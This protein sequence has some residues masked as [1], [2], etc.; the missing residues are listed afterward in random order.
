[1]GEFSGR[2]A[3]RGSGKAG[4]DGAVSW[5]A[6]PAALPTLRVTA[7]RRRHD[8]LPLSPSAADPVEHAAQ[9]VS[10][11]KTTSSAFVGDFGKTLRFARTLVDNL[12][13]TLE[14]VVARCAAVH[15]VTVRLLHRDSAPTACTDAQPSPAAYL[16]TFVCSL[17]VLQGMAADEE[18]RL[19]RCDRLTA[20]N[21]LLIYLRELIVVLR[22][23]PPGTDAFVLYVGIIYGLLQ[24][25]LGRMKKHRKAQGGALLLDAFKECYVRVCT[26]LGVKVRF[27]E[28]PLAL[29][30][31][32]LAA[33]GS[34]GRLPRRAGGRL[35]REAAR[36]ALQVAAGPRSGR[37]PQPR[38]HHRRALLA[39]GGARGSPRA[40]PR[41]PRPRRAAPQRRLSP[42]HN[43]AAAGRCR[44]C[45][46]R[47][48]RA[49][50]PATHGSSRR[51]RG[52]W[53]LCRR[54]AVRASAVRR[55]PKRHHGRFRD[56][57]CN[58]APLR[59]RA[60]PR[61]GAV[62]GRGGV[63]A[64]SLSAESGTRDRAAT[65]RAAGARDDARF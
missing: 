32:L 25:L 7:S 14:S 4:R 56:H 51:A 65:R 64:V 55:V 17:A 53:G 15:P 62:C 54:T 45:S 47:G 20:D 39:A 24:T 23:L 48:I 61:R 11:D 22:A 12:T 37:Q 27:S 29:R 6:T 30:S 5:G 63:I 1:M 19:S 34:G 18:A 3:W 46:S 2:V 8:S 36:L 16:L 58:V 31:A 10:D 26:Q 21:R 60:C 59:R 52:R 43:C 9:L 44:R 35:L 38:R 49:D 41:G 57:V 33:K 28:A 13:V 40:R 50:E 42:H